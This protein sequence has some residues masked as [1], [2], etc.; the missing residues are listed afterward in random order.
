ME[1]QGEP[2]QWMVMLISGSVSLF[3]SI[4]ILILREQFAFSRESREYERWQVGNLNSDYHEE[5]LSEKIKEIQELLLRP[6]DIALGQ[7]LARDQLSR[8][9][10]RIGVKTFIGAIPLRYPLIMNSYQII[11]DWVLV[12][13]EVERIRKNELSQTAAPKGAIPYERRHA[14]WLTLL[15]YM[16][17]KTQNFSIDG[18][19]VEAM[20]KFE[21][22]YIND[23]TILKIED[24]LFRSEQHLSGQVTRTLRR[25]IRR[26]FHLYCFNFL[27]FFTCL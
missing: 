15:A 2:S 20:N 3:V 8:A 21:S 7:N 11:R 16:W 10:Q 22:L 9:I 24:L 14:E 5:Y 25:Q 1:G 18:H 17:T 4:T 23:K 26:N 27:F 12:S 19:Y 13:P 6:A